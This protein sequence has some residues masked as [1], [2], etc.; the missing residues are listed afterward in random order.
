M[1]LPELFCGFPRSGGEPPVAYPVACLPQAWAAAS[2]FGLL[3]ACLGLT[4]DGWR[5]ELHVGSPRLPQG[6]SE[7]RLSGLAIGDRGVDLLFCEAAGRVMV[8]AGRD[9][10]AGIPVITHT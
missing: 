8:L 1:R 3:Q 6:I 10:A 5:R 4:I 7:I 9:E 2:V